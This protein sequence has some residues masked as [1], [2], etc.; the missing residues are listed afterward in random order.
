MLTADYEIA[1]G[2]AQAVLASNTKPAVRAYWR[3]KKWSRLDLDDE[4]ALPSHARQDIE[5]LCSRMELDSKVLTR[6]ISIG[7][8]AQRRQLLRAGKML[9][10]YVTKIRELAREQMGAR[11]VVDSALLQPDGDDEPWEDDKY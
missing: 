8:K 9:A 6:T 7:G 4:A 10:S 2:I 11:F 1:T 5:L 3:L